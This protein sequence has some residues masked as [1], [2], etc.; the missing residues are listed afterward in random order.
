VS[1]LVEFLLARIAEDEAAA[2][3]NV[4]YEENVGETAGWLA[5]SRVLAECEAKRR[6]VEQCR[7]HWVVVFRQSDILLADAF[8]Q[9]KVPTY[10]SSGPI[11]PH[12]AAE[13]TLRAL[14]LPYAGHRDYDEDLQTAPL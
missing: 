4:E 12:S 9:T 1:D 14:A 8:D 7:P 3:E 5:P 6:I 10:A 2:R 11:W 13:A